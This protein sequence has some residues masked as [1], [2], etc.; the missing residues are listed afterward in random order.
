MSWV[1]VA[2][3]SG[4]LGGVTKYMDAKQQQ[5][6]EQAKLMANAAQIQYSPWTG[7]QAQIMGASAPSA[8]GAAIGGALQGGIAGASMAQANGGFGQKP[9]ASSFASNAGGMNGAVNPPMGPVSGNDYTKNFKTL[10]GSLG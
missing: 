9:A 2:V 6:Q 4:V 1:A 5:K 8:T 7:A 3:G 10:Y